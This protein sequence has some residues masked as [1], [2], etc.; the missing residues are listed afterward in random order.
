[1]DRPF[2][3]PCAINISDA[4]GQKVYYPERFHNIAT[5]SR[6][7][8]ECQQSLCSYL[9]QVDTVGIDSIIILVAEP[10]II[11]IEEHR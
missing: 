1:M 5:N 10:C 11:R 3:I 6:I 7:L 4:L 8:T 2:P 9:G